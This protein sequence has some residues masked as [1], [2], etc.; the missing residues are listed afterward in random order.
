MSRRVY[1]H[2]DSRNS[3]EWD[4]AP[5]TMNVPVSPPGVHPGLAT[6]SLVLPLTKVGLKIDNSTVRSAPGLHLGAMIVHSRVCGKSVTFDGHPG[7]SCRHGSTLSAF[8]SQS[9]ERNTVSCI[10]QHRHTG[11]QE[12]S[13]LAWDRCYLS[14]H[15][16]T[17][18]P[19]PQDCPC[20]QGQR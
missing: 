20:R 8:T 1:L 18:M 12:G 4:H 11:H 7:L 6:G 3:H 5:T 16:R 2:G 15:I 10:Q 17:V 9:S 19:K 13:V 14:G